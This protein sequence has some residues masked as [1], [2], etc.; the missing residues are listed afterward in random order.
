VEDFFEDTATAGD[1]GCPIQPRPSGIRA[2]ILVAGLVGGVLG[3]LIGGLGQR[4]ITELF[5]KGS[6]GDSRI[7]SVIM[8]AATADGFGQSGINSRSS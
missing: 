2:H 8:F 6:D 1:S 7:T 3:V 4:Q 5:L